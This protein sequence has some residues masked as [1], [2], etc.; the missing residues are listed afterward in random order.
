MRAA[1]NAGLRPQAT[2]RPTVAELR[3]NTRARSAVL[4]V[5]TKKRQPRLAQ[6]EQRL[7]ALL[8]W[9]QPDVA[10]AVVSMRQDLA[11]AGATAKRNKEEKVKQKEKKQK[12]ARQRASVST[13]ALA[14]SVTGEKR[15]QRSDDKAKESKRAKGGAPGSRKKRKKLKTSSLAEWP[16]ARVDAQ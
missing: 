4:H 13:S 3:E 10:T 14:L 11:N 7:Y 16:S 8:G 15:Q 5:L 1:L 9:K 2:L 6:L 12:E